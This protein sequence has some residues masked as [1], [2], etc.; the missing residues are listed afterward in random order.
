MGGT[1]ARANTD[2]RA[3]D[4]VYFTKADSDRDWPTKY[5]LNRLGIADEEDVG[6]I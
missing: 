2:W 5:E 6:A 3:S 1:V 4:Q